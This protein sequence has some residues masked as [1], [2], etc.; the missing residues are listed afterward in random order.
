M[1]TYHFIT[2]K[3]NNDNYNEKIEKKNLPIL[4]QKYS[5]KKE[6]IYKEYWINHVRIISNDKK[7]NFNYIKDIIIEV[8]DNYL[9]QEYEITP[10]PSFSFYEIDLETEYTLYKGIY[11]GFV[12]IVKEFDIYLT[13]ELNSPIKNHFFLYNN[14]I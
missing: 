6:G 9:I 3:D 12:I 5:L 7:L 11:N 8:S 13:I 10:C 4:I 14:I 2:S 1:F